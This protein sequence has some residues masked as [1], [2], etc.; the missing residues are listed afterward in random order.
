MSPAPVAA[1]VGTGIVAPLSRVP[2][3]RIVAGGARILK[4]GN[5]SGWLFVVLVAGLAEVI[6]RAGNLGDSVAIRIGH[7]AA[8]AITNRCIGTPRPNHR[9]ASGMSATA[10]T[11]RRNS[12]TTDEA[13]SS[14]GELPIAI[15]AT[16]PIAI[17]TASPSA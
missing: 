16:T 11:A 13:A 4:R 10:G 3:G 2:K 5:L 15:P 17:A 7:V 1:A 6:V 9:I 8:Y 14:V 12:S